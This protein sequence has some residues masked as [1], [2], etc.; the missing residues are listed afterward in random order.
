[1]DAGLVMQAY[2]MAMPEIVQA[3]H[4]GVDLYPGYTL[5]KHHEI[6]YARAIDEI[7]QYNDQEEY[8]VFTVDVGYDDLHMPTPIEQTN[9]DHLYRYMRTNVVRDLEQLLFDDTAEV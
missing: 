3:Y 6:T 5:P 2:I 7:V 4:Q 8:I 9:L 1:M